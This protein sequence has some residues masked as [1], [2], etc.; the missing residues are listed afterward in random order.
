MRIN[1]Y[2]DSAFGS[3]GLVST[4]FH[5]QAPIILQGA[6]TLDKHAS[7]KNYVDNKS[8]GLSASNLTGS[9][10]VSF[11]SLMGISGDIAFNDSYGTVGFTNNAVSPGWY[12]RVQVNLKGIVTGVNPLNYT[13]IPDLDWSKITLNKPTT[14]AG[15][16]ITDALGAGGGVINYNI[17]LDH[18]PV[19][20]NEIA[21]KQ[22]AQTLI[23]AG[24]SGMSAGDI[25]DTYVNTTPFG[26]L[27]C[28]GASISK[29]MYNDLFNV[30]GYKYTQMT[31]V[32]AGIPWNQQYNINTGDFAF[33]GSWM[34]GV[35][36]PV[37]LGAF[38]LVVTK[39]RVYTLGG[40]SSSVATDK[41]YTA[42]LNNDGTVGTWAESGTIPAALYDTASV[43]TK[44]KVYLIGGRNAS[45]NPVNTTYSAPV[46]PDGTLGSWTSEANFGIAKAGSV[47]FISNKK[48][49]LVGGSNS[50]TYS[51][52]INED[53][54]LSSGWTASGVAP[55]TL[56]YPCLAIT[57]DLVYLIGGK[58]GSGSV[59][60]IYVAPIDSNGAL[61]TFTTHK[62]KLP[63]AMFK[64][65]AIVTRNQITVIGG[66]SNG[67]QGSTTITTFT[68]NLD[69]TIKELGTSPGNLPNFNFDFRCMITDVKFYTI[70]G[71][72]N[73]NTYMISALGGT[74]NYLQ[75]YDDDSNVLD[76]NYFNVPDLIEDPLSNRHFYIKY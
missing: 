17:K 29:S 70:G 63:S 31:P 76:L 25:L 20:A 45:G 34:L 10:P 61:G 21:T 43:V 32:G 3:Q 72:G 49:Y 11:T 53:G 69:G 39:D 40:F 16:G 56:E 8:M 36:L 44:N 19:T 13:D 30:I 66:T 12:T 64:S 24:G 46:N 52:S 73:S 50:T 9:T 74:N 4:G 41:I 28:N 1:V 33:S 54:D 26:F 51:A 60:T 48:I 15:Y 67:T 37:Q 14:V 5:A 59:D 57:K 65:Q 55:A 75:Y 6:P 71:N 27:R 7:T 35:G 2:I 22:Y 58:V 68:L 47:A 18:N 42:P 62:L 23:G 38:S